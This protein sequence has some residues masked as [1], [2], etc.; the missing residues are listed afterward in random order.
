MHDA[1]KRRSNLFKY[2]PWLRCL[3]A[4]LPRN[5]K[6]DMHIRLGGRT[7]LWLNNETPFVAPVELD[8]TDTSLGFS[9]VSITNDLHLFWQAG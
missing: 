9:L 6:S 1:P 5:G 4:N 3:F 7:M 2:N 8:A